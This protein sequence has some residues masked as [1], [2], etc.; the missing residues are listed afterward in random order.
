MFQRI[1]FD[2]ETEANV[3]TR[4]RNKE[5]LSWPQETVDESVRNE[6]KGSKHIWRQKEWKDMYTKLTEIRFRV[7]TNNRNPDTKIHET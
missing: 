3:K 7:N 6:P 2:D 4:T 5:S 1:P